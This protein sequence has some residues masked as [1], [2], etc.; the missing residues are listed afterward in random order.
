MKKFRVN[1]KGL[2]RCQSA[3]LQFCKLTCVCR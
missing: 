2:C 3:W 1:T